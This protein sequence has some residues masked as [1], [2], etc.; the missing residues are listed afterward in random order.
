MDL[1]DIN[2]LDFSFL[3]DIDLSLNDINI[4]LDDIKI[5]KDFNIDIN[6]DDMQIDLTQIL[7]TLYQDTDIT[8]TF[9]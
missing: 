4:D 5:D 9:N 6:L 3:D 8:T 1:S 7:T 2:E